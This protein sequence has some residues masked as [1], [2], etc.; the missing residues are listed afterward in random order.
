MTR[1]NKVAD[2]YPT[3]ALGNGWCRS[4]RCPLPWSQTLPRNGRV[5]SRYF[6]AQTGTEPG[7]IEVRETQT[8]EDRSKPLA[9]RLALEAA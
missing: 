7:R 2:G 9:A 1:K 3:P 5:R 6:I 8:V 4:S